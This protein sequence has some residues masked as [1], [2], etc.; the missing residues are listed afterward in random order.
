[1]VSAAFRFWVSGSVLAGMIGHVISCAVSNPTKAIHRWP[2]GN[3]TDSGA[4]DL[5]RQDHRPR[6]SGVQ[7]IDPIVTPIS[8]CYLR[9]VQTKP[10]DPSAPTQR[11]ASLPPSQRH[12]YVADD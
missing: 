8:P 1:M 5:G 11:V 10:P 6:G 7:Q 2:A 3:G 9:A 4:G 12:N